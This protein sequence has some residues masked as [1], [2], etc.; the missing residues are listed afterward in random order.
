MKQ[1]HKELEFHGLT[2]GGKQTQ[3]YQIWSQ[4]KQR[5]LNP[6]YRKY[7]NYGGRGIDMDPRW[8]ESF[9]AFQED[10]GKRPNRRYSIER[11]DNDKGYWPDNVRW[12][13]LKEQNR[14][15]RSNLV[16]VYQG[17][18]MP[19]AELAEQ[20]GRSPKRLRERIMSGMSAEEAVGRPIEKRRRMFTLD[21]E[22]Y[23]LVDWSQITGV[24]YQTLR[25]R[26]YTKKWSLRDALL[27]PV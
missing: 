17:E 13:T 5:C 6:N 16:V 12:A 25:S 23:S 24:N 14:N 7:E 2:A 18:Q 3:L 4:I 11:I 27:T 19:L 8:A 10:V 9:L 15:K 26:I 22:S 20:T 1:T 21:G